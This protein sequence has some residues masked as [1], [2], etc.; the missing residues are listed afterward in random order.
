MV[1]P[2]THMLPER[3]WFVL[4]R[5][6]VQGRGAFAARDIPAGQR[7]IEYTGERIS[8]DE[9]SRRY[10][11][12]RATRHHTFLF[13]LDEETCIDARHEGNDA[14]FINHSCEPNC[15]ALNEEGRIF[16]YSLVDIPAGVELSYDY[17]YVIEGALDPATRKLYACRCGARRCRGT[18][19]V[20]KL[21]PKARAKLARPRRKMGKRPEK[22]RVA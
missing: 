1:R 15:E 12:S 8:S 18:I 2:N 7:L 16:I 5:S 14:R 11:D 6:P 3:P 9:A 20:A 13:E 19:A 4:R 21:K 10:D 22:A 17:Q